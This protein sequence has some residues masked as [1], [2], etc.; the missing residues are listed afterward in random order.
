[1]IHTKLNDEWV[2]WFRDPNNNDWSI[3]SYKEMYTFSSVEEFWELIDSIKKITHMIFIFRK[4]IKPIYED[5]KN[6]NGGQISVRT[7]FKTMMETF[8]EM[9]SY[10]VS[11]NSCNAPLEIN[12]LTLALKGR[13]CLIKYWV[14]NY[15]VF[16]TNFLETRKINFNIKKN[17]M[18]DI[19]IKKNIY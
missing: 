17:Y 18:N 7:P 5:E 19:R 15:E 10:M 6:I 4:G 9:T 14:K 1:M 3:Q 16:S 8:K 13:S 2:L 11:E 12:G